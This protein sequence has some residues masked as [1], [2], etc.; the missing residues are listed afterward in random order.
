[1]LQ[2][3]KK[4]QLKVSLGDPRLDFKESSAQ[5]QNEL[6]RSTKR[7]KITNMAVFATL[8]SLNSSKYE[9]V[10]IPYKQLISIGRSSSK[11]NDII[12]RENDCSSLHCQF[13][14]GE[15]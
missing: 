2:P 11:N 7:P 13:V 6:E 4:R 8:H 10:N 5:E 9:D 15:S 3:G 1:M 14:I 12:I